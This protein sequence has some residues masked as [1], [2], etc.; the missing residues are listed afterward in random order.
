MSSSSGSPKSSRTT[1]ASKASARRA[2]VEELQ[3]AE[4][5]RDRRRTLLVVAALAVVAVVIVVVLV[6]VA[7]SGGTS[8]PAVAGDAQ[9][10]LAAA[11]SGPV[12]VQKSPKSVPDT[13][14]IPGVLAWD[15]QGYPGNGQSYPGALTHEHVPGPVQYAVLPPVGGPHNAIWMNAG[16]YTEPVPSERAVHDLEHGAVWIVYDP[17]LPA[18]QVAQLTAFVSGQ[19]LV[20]EP[21]QQGATAG[22]QANRYVDLSP[23]GGDKLPA[24]IVISAWGHQLRVQSPT[25]PR[26]QRFVDTFR[27]NATYSPEFGSPVDGIP[28]ETG[29]RPATDGSREPNPAGSVG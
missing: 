6:V 2:R 3:R 18:G 13:S 22:N 20:S 23:W 5:A 14:G 7:K 19:S 21:A 8:T 9:Q 15:T 4:L 25:D 26:L 10:I 16:V 27:N 28:V 11:P 1:K 24:P 29:G 17:S 12:T